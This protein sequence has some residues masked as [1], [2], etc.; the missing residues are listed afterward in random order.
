MPILQQY[1][2]NVHAHK[3]KKVIRQTIHILNIFK[4]E[5]KGYATKFTKKNEKRP[6]NIVPNFLMSN[7][8]IYL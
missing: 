8:F 1:Q 6:K 5:Q 4:Q 7:I 3:T 2:S